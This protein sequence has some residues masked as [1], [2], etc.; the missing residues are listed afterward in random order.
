MLTTLIYV[1]ILWGIIALAW[2]LAWWLKRI[3][4]VQD[5]CRPAFIARYLVCSRS[6]PGLTAIVGLASSQVSG[7]GIGCPVRFAMKHAVR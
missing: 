4:S 7:D 2:L 3:I 1:L 6:R 5:W